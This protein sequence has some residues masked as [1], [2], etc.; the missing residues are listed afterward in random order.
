MKT[1]E[2]DPNDPEPGP[3]AE[4]ALIVKGGSGSGEHHRACVEGG[5][6]R[7][8]SIRDLQQLDRRIWVRT[9]RRPQTGGGQTDRP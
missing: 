4:P 3:P 7:R 2:L 9:D 1:T 6:R 5:Y 8:L